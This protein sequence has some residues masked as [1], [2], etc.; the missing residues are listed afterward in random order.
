M[1][2]LIDFEKDIPKES[3]Y[4]ILE[5]LNFIKDNKN[6]IKT[7]FIVKLVDKE[8]ITIGSA[9]DNDIVDNIGIISRKH[10]IIK[11]DEGI[12]II[13]NKS[14]TYGTFALIKGNIKILK[15]DINFQVGNSYIT[16]KLK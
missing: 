8:S 3:D 6:N 13:E 14:E 15:E 5:S 16:A 12:A 2:E 4:I 10:A 9:E 1:Y 11:Y 7:I